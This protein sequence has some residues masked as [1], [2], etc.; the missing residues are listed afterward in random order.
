MNFEK[1]VD[2][3]AQIIENNI[4]RLRSSNLLKHAV[5]RMSSENLFELSLK[6]YNKLSNIV[7]EI[8][9]ENDLSAKFPSNLGV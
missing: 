5:Y 8:S 1:Y 7:N 2:E 4:Y 3:I 6:E 9:N